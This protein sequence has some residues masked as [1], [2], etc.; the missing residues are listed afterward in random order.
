[1]RLRTGARGSAIIAIIV[2][3]SIIISISNSIVYYD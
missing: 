2:M 3:S 1:M